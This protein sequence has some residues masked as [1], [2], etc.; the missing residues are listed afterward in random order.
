MKGPS[1]CAPSDSAPS[2]GTRSFG[3]ARKG[4]V[5]SIAAIS[6]SD[7]SGIELFMVEETNFIVDLALLTRQGGQIACD[8][9]FNQFPIHSFEV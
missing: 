6:F 3:A 4:R 8:P 7:S 1:Q 2:S 5:Y 9:R